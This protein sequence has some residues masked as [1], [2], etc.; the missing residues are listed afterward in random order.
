MTNPAMVGEV[1]K[2]VASLLAANQPL[3]L[4]GVGTLRPE[5]K[6]AR[7]LSRRKLAPPYR[8]VEYTSREEGLSMPEAIARA[9]RCDEERARTVYERWLSYVFADGVLT[10]EGV[11]RLRQ[12]HFALDP[13]FEQRLNPQGHE[14]IRIRRS[15]RFDWVLW[16]GVAAILFVGGFWGY[17]FLRLRQAEWPAGVR[18]TVVGVQPVP[19][20]TEA[21]QSADSPAGAPAGGQDGV[22]GSAADATGTAA[23]QDRADVSAGAAAVSGQPAAADPS[24]AP[25]VTERAVSSESTDGMP[26]E[27][28]RAAAASSVTSPAVSS[29]VSPAASPAAADRSALVS[30][31]RYV[32]LGVFSTPGN[33]ERAAQQAAERVVGVRCTVHPF[34]A[35][36][37]VSPFASD[38]AAACTRFV[39][40]YDDRFPGLWVYVAR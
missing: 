40:K 36:W 31:R 27:A 29:E 23:G 30:G 34:G 2:L 15:R 22:A 20:L 9:A 5:R 17:Q 8:A 4:P 38:D 1:N 32:V 39:N 33:A 7:R 6:A 3:F 25:V 16:L 13:A 14:P 26:A 24:S 18:P 35:K 12:K 28:D 11:G 10:I 37:M 19:V 21:A